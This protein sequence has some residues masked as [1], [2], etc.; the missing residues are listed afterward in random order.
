MAGVFPVSIV[1]STRTPGSIAASNRENIRITRHPGR[2]SQ[3]GNR[4]AFTVRAKPARE[5]NVSSTAEA[6]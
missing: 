4:V 2:M 3:D 1:F 6:S 5:P